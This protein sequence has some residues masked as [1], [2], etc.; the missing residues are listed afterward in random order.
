MTCVI[1]AYH[2]GTP[3]D[4]INAFDMKWNT[5]IGY[6]FESV[7]ALAMSY[8]FMVTGFL[9]FYDLSFKNYFEKIRKRLY[10][11]LLPYLLW[12]IIIMLKIVIMGGQG[13]TL[14]M[15]LERTFLMQ[16]WPPD[17]ALWYLYA[18]F[19]LALISP[20]FIIIFKNKSIG[21][22]SVMVLMI[23][24]YRLNLLSDSMVVAFRSYGYIGNVL[25]YFPSYIIGAYYG[26]HTNEASNDKELKYILAILFMAMFIEGLYSG[27]FYD[28]TKKV[29]PVLLLYLFPIIPCLKERKIYRLSFLIYAVHHPITSDILVFL[30]KIIRIITPYACISNVITRIICL[31]VDFVIAGI[32]YAILEKFAPKILSILTGGRAFRSSTD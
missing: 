10:S 6:T 13:W 21:L 20:I 24:V 5:F 9:L 16:S 1:A 25:Y 7:A 23:A 15:F 22:L 29:M 28:V 30:R 3:K 27:F 14:R 26:I 2:C 17:G 19:V 32:V 12:Q 4:P 18:V 31:G 11:L 8:F